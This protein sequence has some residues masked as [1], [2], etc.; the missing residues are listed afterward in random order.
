MRGKIEPVYAAS[1]T[2]VIAVDPFFHPD[3]F[4]ER[5]VD[6][7]SQ[8]QGFELIGGYVD[9]QMIGYGFGCTRAADRAGSIWDDV[10]NTIPNFAI[11][12]E[13]QPVFI[14]NEFAVHPDHQ[15]RGYGRRILE[16][17]LVRRSEAIANLYVRPDNPARAHYLAWGWR[18][19][20]QKKPFDDSPTF[21][22]LIKDLRVL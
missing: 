7:Y 2:D 19:I 6:M 21:D 22:S 9:G 5:L 3:R 12:A 13:P 4:W 14:F 8:A 1:H 20:A 16:A 17:L 10:R 11:P 15:N 18:K